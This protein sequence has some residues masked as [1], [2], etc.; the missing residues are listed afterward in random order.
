[1][2]AA[3]NALQYGALALGRALAGPP[4][5]LAALSMSATVMAAVLRLQEA[6]ALDP[7]LFASARRRVPLAA[8]LTLWL[9]GI[10]LLAAYGCA[11]APS[12]SGHLPVKL[13]GATVL[14]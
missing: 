11:L 14:N 3:L 6:G 5:S 4:M 12:P 9:A 10:G 7:G 2:F 1:V 13:R 8:I